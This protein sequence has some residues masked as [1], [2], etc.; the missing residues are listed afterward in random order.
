MLTAACRTDGI[1]YYYDLVHQERSEGRK[2]VNYQT[3][4]II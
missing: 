2:T 4:A 3:I 1:T